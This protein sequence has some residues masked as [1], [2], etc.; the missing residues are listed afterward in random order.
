VYNY[1]VLIRNHTMA[2]A[3]LGKEGLRRPSVLSNEM[4]Q[5]GLASEDDAAVLGEFISK[6]FY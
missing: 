5:E 6:I 3:P 1:H 4:V 2:D